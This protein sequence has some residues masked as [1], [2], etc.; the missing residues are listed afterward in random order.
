MI[1]RT[2]TKPWLIVGIAAMAGVACAG[3]G[4]TPLVVY[5]PHGRDLLLLAEETFEA[6][7][8][9]VDVRWLDMGSQDVLDRLRSERANPQAD[10]WFGGP[11]IL[12]QRGVQ[13][14]LLIP[15]TPSWAGSI[16]SRGIG[17]GNYYHSVYETPAV[18]AFNNSVVSRE[19]AP[20]DWDEVLDPRWDQLVVIRDPLASGTMR[21]IFGMIINRSVRT[22]GDTAS[23]FEWLRR[24][25]GQTR[26][27]T[28]NPSL[29]HQALLRQEGVVTLW[30]LPD[31]L[32]ENSEGQPFDYILPTSGTPVIQDAIAVVAG[33]D[34]E[35]VARRFVD[36][37]GSMEFQL[38][39][40]RQNFRLPSRIDLPQD[41]LP[42]WVTTVRSSLVVEDMDWQLVAENGADWMQYW[43]RN[44]RG[45]GD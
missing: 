25:D 22:T 2:A 14:S 27:Y 7:N 40:A 30:D 33:T 13:D 44:V 10:I 42:A 5:S 45:S 29:L 37:V 8:P 26:Q 4:R 3:D 31:I 32:I 35:E 11:S 9:D 28:L 36:F 12:F 19:E 15:Y 16:E 41:S 17:A 43:D 20:K 34:N 38:A 24:L 18:I 1:S 21:S 23:G 6:A 39:A